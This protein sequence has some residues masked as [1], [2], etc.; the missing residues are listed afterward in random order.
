[1][2]EYKAAIWRDAESETWFCRIYPEAD[3]ERLAAW[4][5][6]AS[7]EPVTVSAPGLR[8]PYGLGQVI[9]EKLN[10]LGLAVA[11]FE[12]CNLGNLPAGADVRAEL[13]AKLAA[14]AA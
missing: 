2:L 11:K 8:G 9:A 12:P 6:T 13:E 3:A 4:G 1:M 14:V 5:L 7:L 10:E